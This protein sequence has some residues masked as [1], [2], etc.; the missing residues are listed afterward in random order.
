MA[1]KPTYEELEQSVKEL[2]K[3]VVERQRMEKALLN[4]P[5]DVA[6]VID[7]KAII[8][9]A[10]ETVAR[11]FGRRKD[12][13]IGMCVWDLLTPEVAERRNAFVSKVIQSGKSVRVEDE[14]GGNWYDNVLY[15]ILDEQGKVT[16]IVL[17]ARDITERR[18]AEEKLRLMQHCIDNASDAI[19]WVDDKARFVYVNKAACRH[20]GY[21][22]EDLLSMKVHDVDPLY[23]KDNWPDFWR[24]FK[25]KGSLL[26][27]SINTAKYGRE[28]PVEIAVCYL[29]YEGKEIM[30]AYVRDI[31]ERKRAEEALR[32][33]YHEVELRVEKRTAELAK[34]TEQLKKEMQ[35]HNKAEEMLRGSE[36][37]L[38]EV[39]DLVPHAIYAYDRTGLH[40]LANRKAAELLGT[41]VEE[42]TGT[43]FEDIFSNREQLSR[44]LADTREVI[45][46]GQPKFVPEE[47]ILDA[48][49]NLRFLQTSKIPFTWPDS[50]EQV[51]VG[52]SVD[53]TEHKVAEERLHKMKDCF[54]S[55]GS[56]AVENINK[57]TGL[58]G[59]V[60]GGACALYNRLAGELLCSVGQWNT[61]QDYDPRDRPEGHICFDVIQ[62]GQDEV[63]VVRD[64]PNTPYAE[65]D[66]NVIPYSL[67]TYIG[68]SVKCGGKTVGS[69]CVVF[70][71]DIVPSEDDKRVL[72][73]A[74]SAIGIEEE[75][76]L[77][78][79]ALLGKEKELVIRSANLE[80]SNVALKVLLKRR[81]ED[82]VQLE[83][84]VLSNVNQLIVPYIEKLKEGE[85]D[86]RQEAYLNIL[87]SNLE[88]IISPFSRTLSY[89]HLN[90]T[91]TE[92]RVSN[93]IRHGKSTKQIAELLNVSDRTI[94]SH[95]DSIRNKLGIKQKRA[96]LRTY[97]LSI[98]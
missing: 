97:L 66:P 23:Q 59:E 52:V 29:E 24:E 1:R 93:L 33:A 60:L 90:L 30:H 27:D 53:I 36:A 16:R 55:F 50:G 10:N 68:K 85:M 42:L 6:M 39:I 13:L 57:L 44:F 56:D 22:R 87:K 4:T 31:T 88:E 40:V 2:E 91:P 47:P 7:T 14:R 19:F 67:Q 8:L 35:E 37:L 89:S 92:L 76:E 3:E 18:R 54:L 82:R 74:A 49:G 73:I 20:M 71:R 45:A 25:D 98:Q 38:R 48:E 77:V 51:V 79:A 83:E 84:Q 46:S 80:E 32:K 94:D 96:N 72:E 63:V 64:L 70:Q 9:D 78:Q 5:T 12:E 58:C 15:P 26:F 21:S 81:D 86:L 75:R 34:A 61:P 95:R 28:I 65:S 17:L 41:T 62:E 11:G 69:L 43:L